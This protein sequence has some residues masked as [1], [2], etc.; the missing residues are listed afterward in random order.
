[1][2]YNAKPKLIKNCFDYI[3]REKE[4][5]YLIL[6]NT[7]PELGNLWINETTYSILKSFD[8]EKNI[9]EIINLFISKFVNLE[10]K[11]IDEDIKNVLSRFSFFGLIDWQGYENPFQISY[12]KSLNNKFILKVAEEKDTL[13]ILNFI[14]SSS[15]LSKGLLSSYFNIKNY[16]HL[17]LRARIF[18]KIEEFFILYDKNGNII[19]IIS[20]VMPNLTNSTTGLINFI[21]DISDLQNVKN[22]IDFAIIAIPD[23]SIIQLNKITFLGK[24]EYK[25]IL[26]SIFSDIGFVNE[27]ILKN[28]TSINS[29]DYLWSYFYEK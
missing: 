24:E 4:N 6:L 16:N 11:T 9:K 22:L 17:S 21:A 1:M 29:L 26:N 2:Y 3:R 28:E 18:Q 5:N 15:E 10:E 20:V 27:S 7:H 13:E 25:N 23:I 19:N 14:K 12:E 8:G